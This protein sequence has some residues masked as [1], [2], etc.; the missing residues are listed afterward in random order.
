MNK[1]TFIGLFSLFPF[2]FCQAQTIITSCSNAFVDAGGTSSSYSNNEISDWLI[3]PSEENVYL[4]LMFTYVDIEVATDMG[5]D[6]SGCRDMLYIYDGMNDTAPLVGQ[7]CGQ[8]STDGQAA[9]VEENT[10]QLGDSFKP[11]NAS[12]CFYLKFESDATNARSG[13]VADVS[14]CAPTTQEPATD[15]VDCPV[16]TN[17]GLWFSYDIDNTCS[18]VGHLYNITDKDG[19]S[20]TPACVLNAEDKKYKTYYA[21]TANDNGGFTELDIDPI[22]DLGAISVYALGPLQNGCPEY[23]GGYFAHCDEAE[24]PESFFFNMGPNSTYLLVV[25]SDEPGMFNMKNTSASTSLPIEMIEYNLRK[26][27]SNAELRWRTANEVNNHGFDVLRSLDGL[28]FEKIAF[29]EAS[30]SENV[31]QDYVYVDKSELLEGNVYYYLSQIDLD[32]THTDYPIQALNF[33]TEVTTQVYPNPASKLIKVEGLIERPVSI[34]VLD[35]QGAEKVYLR[36]QLPAQ[37]DVSA[38]SSGL[39]LIEVDYGTHKE[40]IKQL[41]EH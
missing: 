2:L 31:Q 37:L 6:N 27:G 16:S 9:F 12:R 33:E 8:A 36:Q 5:V 18:R 29:V 35:M 19:T 38:L 30:K 26:I 1:L 40:I 41:I 7:Y 21:F 23:T 11:S 4:D 39:Y 22:D 13:W 3:C 25:A 32:G 34:R 28:Q 14:C 15:G 10:I 24:D 17:N 20:I